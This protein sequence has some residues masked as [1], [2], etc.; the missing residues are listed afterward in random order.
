MATKTKAAVRSGSGKGGRRPPVKVKRGSDV[1]LL[2]IAVAGILLAFAIGVI[3]YIVVNN[4]KPTPQPAV[5]AGIPCDHL[6]HSTVHYHAAV[7]II[8]GGTVHPIAPNIGITGDPASPTCYYWLHVHAGNQNT[9]H[10]E[11]PATQTFTLGQF[12]AVWS[13]WS[14]AKGDPAQP[15]DATHISTFTLT[16]DQTVKV[17]IDLQDGKGPQPYTGDPS[18]IVLKSHEVISLV[19][20]PP[21]TT[22]PAFTFASGL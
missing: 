20:S 19:I 14:Q 11:A 4:P 13:T 18:A 3:I 12:F 9:I 21:D 22:P 16:P 1:P 10:I 6:E 2:P 5:A 17:Y 8:Y 7:Q 15:L